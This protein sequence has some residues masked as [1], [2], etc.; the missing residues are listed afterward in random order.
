MRLGVAARNFPPWDAHFGVY[1]VC[2]CAWGAID[3]LK[4][5]RVLLGW[6]CQPHETSR[7]D[8]L[9][10]AARSRGPKCQA[11]PAALGL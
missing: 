5:G 1:L 2:I 3:V 9:A 7:A 6:S 11:W 4:S 8:T 10:T